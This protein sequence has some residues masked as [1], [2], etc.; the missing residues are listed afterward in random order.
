MPPNSTPPR[1]GMASR[2]EG[3]PLG[4]LPRFPADHFPLPSSAGLPKIEADSGLIRAV[5]GERVEQSP[6][7]SVMLTAR[8]RS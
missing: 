8:G 2:W 4:A 6:R 3:C 1:E 5:E 7:R